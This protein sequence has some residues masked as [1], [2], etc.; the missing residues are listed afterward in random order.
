MK[1]KD[2]LAT[3]KSM[4]VLVDTR[5]QD[6]PRAR[7]RLASIGLPVDRVALD[8]GDYT[9]NATLPSGGSIYDLSKGRIRPSCAIERKMD[10]DELAQ[11]YCGSRDRFEREWERAQ[12]AGARLWLIVE[13]SSWAMIY[14]HKYRTR[15]N[16]DA[17]IQ[18]ILAYQC[19]YDSR[20]IMC[21]EFSS[22]R[23]IRD[24]L[25]RDLKERLERGDYG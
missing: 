17:F 11:C 2:I 16:H 22:G 9:Y 13:N 14:A 6:T 18:S 4:R 25:Y 3:L 23:L 24:I 20:L 8:Y 12:E 19:R 21:D 10:L 7:R 1:H 5:E 15:M